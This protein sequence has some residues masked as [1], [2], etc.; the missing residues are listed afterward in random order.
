[1]LLPNGA[2]WSQDAQSLEELTSFFTQGQ[3]IYN[4]NDLAKSRG[5]ALGNLFEQAVTQAIGMIMEPRKIAAN[6]PVIQNSILKRSESYVQNYQ[7]LSESSESGTYK[8]RAQV[9]ITMDGLRRDLQQLGLDQKQ[10][11]LED[12]ADRDK[13]IDNLNSEDQILDPDTGK[14]VSPDSELP[15]SSA[16]SL[17]RF[18]TKILW[19]VA[20]KIG[21]EWRIARD[22]ES[23]DAIFALS[24][25]HESQSYDIDLVFDEEQSVQVDPNGSVSLKSAITSAQDSE[26]QAVVIGTAALEKE[27]RQQT[28]KVDLRILSSTTLQEQGEV[29]LERTVGDATPEERALELAALTAPELER[30]LLQASQAKA[31]STVSIGDTGS[32]T[33]V[34]NSY[35]SLSNWEELERILRENLKSLKVKDMELGPEEIRARL[36]GV[37]PDLPSQLEGIRL[38][39]G[40]QVHVK[41]YSQQDRTLNVELAPGG[42]Y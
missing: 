17:P 32:L 12:D 34:V 33:L 8:V 23:S 9:S 14:G 3:S 38:R 27:N 36:E 26:A 15:P 37:T 1:M 30:I 16:S 2:A 39:G 7:V 13:N 18:T 21:G 5:E 35:Q 31:P 40:R 19:A 20:E 25:F 6:Y 41:G 42:S 29:H 22:A 28:L 4:A 24:V 11:A 10:V